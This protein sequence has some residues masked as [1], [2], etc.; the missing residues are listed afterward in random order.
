MSNLGKER[1]AANSAPFPNVVSVKI[2]EAVAL[3]CRR[4]LSDP[5]NSEERQ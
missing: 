2:P 5:N 4:L 3:H 1:I